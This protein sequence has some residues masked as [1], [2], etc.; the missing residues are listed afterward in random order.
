CRRPPR[1]RQKWPWLMGGIRWET[2]LARA[3]PLAELLVFQSLRARPP[4]AARHDRTGHHHFPHMS[5][6]ILVESPK[7]SEFEGD[8]VG[9]RLHAAA[10]PATFVCE[11]VS[12]QVSS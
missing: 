5:P 9:A 4:R 11:S 10:G 3:E 6:R 12:E 7:K 1:L 8:V 2:R